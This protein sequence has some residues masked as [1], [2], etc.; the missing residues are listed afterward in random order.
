MR[1]PV[2]S[3]TVVVVMGVAASGKSTLGRVLAHR[4]GVP[5]VEGDGLHP[6]A[7]IARMSAGEALDDE[8][9]GPWLDAVAA[10]IRAAGERGEGL[11][12][13]CSALK[14]RYRRLFRA[15]AP[16]VWFLHLALDPAVARARIAGRTGHFMPAAL[17]DSQYEALE[18]LRADEPGLTVDAAVGT[19]AV[20]AAAEAAL[21][22]F[23]AREP[24]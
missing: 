23:E 1:T 15:A 9:R 16:A 18:P 21:A 12:I 19:E 24:S 22:D 13:S 4:R 20:L 10:R 11:V 17:L 14:Y 5:F 7:N 2:P 3:P 6:T 8:D